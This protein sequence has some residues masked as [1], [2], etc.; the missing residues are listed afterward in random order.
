MC[1]AFNERIIFLIKIKTREQKSFVKLS[2]KLPVYTIS[3][4][5]TFIY[6]YKI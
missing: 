4:R 5:E 2:F 1:P 3:P 6:F